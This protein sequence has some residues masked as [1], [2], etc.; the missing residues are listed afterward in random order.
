MLA[1]IPRGTDTDPAPA[2]LMRTSPGAAVI[3]N[4]KTERALTLSNPST[5]ADAAS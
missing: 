3:A 5:S 1:P 4:L 2:S